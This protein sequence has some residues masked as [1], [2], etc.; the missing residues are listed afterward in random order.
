MAD[1]EPKASVME[2]SAHSEATETQEPPERPKPESTGFDASPEEVNHERI[3]DEEEDADDD[4]PTLRDVNEPSEL[5]I[6]SIEFFEDI[7]QG[8]I[9]RTRNVPADQKHR[10]IVTSRG[11]KSRTYKSIVLLTTVV[12]GFLDADA[13]PPIPATL[14]VLDYRLNGLKKKK[15]NYASV[16]TELE[17]ANT[18]PGLPVQEP[19]VRAFA[20]FDQ[21]GFDQ[22]TWKEEHITTTYKIT[23]LEIDAGIGSG[24]VEGD[25]GQE[26][27]RTEK[28]R[29][30]QLFQAS[31]LSVKDG[32]KGC[33]TVWWNLRQSEGTKEG[34]PPLFRTAVLI[35]RSDEQSQFK[36]RFIMALETGWWT[37]TKNKFD[38]WFGI[39]KDDPLLFDPT[40]QDRGCPEGVDKRRLGKLMEKEDLSGLGGYRNLAD[41]GKKSSSAGKEEK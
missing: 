40:E 33:D 25:L 32:M 30:F 2:E 35:E 34:V 5:S 37:S 28:K 29:Y 26:R 12:H 20:P 6:V 9:L 18:T 36:A 22:E 41:L 39:S 21:A 15:P 13:T 1:Q 23:A 10:S 7:S 4:Y 17:F 24:R 14:I 8:A 3:N 16:Y 11:D 31:C 27:E 19:F 38:R